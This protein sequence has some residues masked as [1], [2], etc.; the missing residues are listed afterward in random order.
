MSKPTER[1]GEVV[2]TALDAAGI[3]E[4]TASQR[5]GIPRETLRRRLVTGDFK[6]GE[7]HRI[8]EVLST[9]PADLV[10]LTREDAA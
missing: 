2:R 7:L 3:S 1:L 10:A 9:T 8:A 5:S 4:N 6:F